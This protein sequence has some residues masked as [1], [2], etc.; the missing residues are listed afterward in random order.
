MTALYEAMMTTCTLLNKIRTPDGLGGWVTTWEDGV[1]FD[2]AILK[3]NTLEARIAEKDGLTQIYTVTTKRANVL[4]FHDVFRR[5]SDKQIFRVTS[6]MVDNTSPTFSGI[7]F[8]QA[9]AE[10]WTLE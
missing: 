9:T 2:A 5:E 7:D 3:D 4:D 1:T 8:G 10:A 6:N